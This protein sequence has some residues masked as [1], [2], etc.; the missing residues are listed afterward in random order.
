MRS[1]RAWLVI[2]AAV[3]CVAVAAL[4]LLP[5]L[6]PQRSVGPQPTTAPLPGEAIPLPAPQREGSVS[7]E[8][9]LQQ[10][11]SVRDYS[12]AP[13][14][15]AQVA[16]LL[17]AAQ[18]VTDARGYRTAPSAG[19][20][21]PL[22]LYLVVRRVDGLSAG[23]YKY[24][25]AAHAL[26]PWLDDD[27]ADELMGAALSQ[28]YIREAAA[29]LVFTAVYERTRTRYGYRAAQYVHME[30]GHASQNVYLQAQALGLGTVAIGAFEDAQVK[31]IL[32]LPADEEPLYIM[33]LGRPRLSGRGP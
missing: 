31:H 8:A 23:V 29:N 2:V 11:R 3:L 27:L 17:W 16:Q 21:Y 19:G 14:N 22:E 26:L 20:L 18:G 10:R 1:I 9:A 30:A 12:D 6:A 32:A 33:P 15:M 5:R 4:V 7:V 25:P 13:L 28:P 24:Q